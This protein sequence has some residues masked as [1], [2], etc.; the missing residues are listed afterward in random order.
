[1]ISGPRTPCVSAV[2][3]GDAVETTGDALN[4]ETQGH[5]LI[6]ASRRENIKVE[7]AVV[8]IEGIGETYIQIW[9]EWR[10]VYVAGRPIQVGPRLISDHLGTGVIGRD[11]R[12]HHSATRVL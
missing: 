9:S 3:N 12:E 10:Y 4:G 2:L 6:K 1:P 8:I 5:V 7:V 11:R